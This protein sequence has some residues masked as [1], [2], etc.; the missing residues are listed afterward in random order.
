MEERRNHSQ[1]T[2]GLQM[3]DFINH[4]PEARAFCESVLRDASKFQLFPGEK[5]AEIGMGV[6][7][8][9]GT[10]SQ[11]E[12]LSVEALEKMCT[13][14]A[15]EGLWGGAEHDPLIQVTGRIIAA[16]IFYHPESDTHFLATVFGNYDPSKLPRFRDLGIT[17]PDV[18]E[19]D[20]GGLIE[21]DRPQV[22]LIYNS[23]EI[24]S[25]LI[26]DAVKEAPSVLDREVGE[27]LRK[28]ADPLATIHLYVKLGF[29]LLNPF[30]KKFLEQMGKRLAD[31]CVDFWKWVATSLWKRVTTLRKSRL[32][33][34]FRTEYKGCDIE[35]VLDTT[36][37]G[38]VSQALPVLHIGAQS[39]VKLVDA[40]EHL[41]PDKLVYEFVPGE[42]TWKPL[43]A[44]T[45]GAGVIAER[46]VLVDFRRYKG[47]SIGGMKHTRK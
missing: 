37:Q 6:I 24:P 30:S 33:V 10:D 47:L 46:P 34:V 1:A 15:T 3:P 29:L 22:K 12:S 21:E 19:D 45:R 36:D 16:R 35:F 7:S 18:C 20:V 38:V 17:I 13:Q 41:K 43:H 32:L 44:A 14:I 23:H 2:D 5:F 26:V 25:D 39:A 9:T 28:A 42:S 4:V 40:L 31:E 11:G 27:S 8:T